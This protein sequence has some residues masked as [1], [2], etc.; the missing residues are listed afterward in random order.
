[1]SPMARSFLLR[2]LRVSVVNLL[3]TW[4]GMISFANAA[5]IY[6]PD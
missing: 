5:V 4:A 6:Q 2:A 3:I 1:M